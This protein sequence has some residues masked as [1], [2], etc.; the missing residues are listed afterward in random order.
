MGRR[1]GQEELT[2]EMGEDRGRMRMGD[3]EGNDKE[4]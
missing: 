2:T 3:E 4:T 1:V